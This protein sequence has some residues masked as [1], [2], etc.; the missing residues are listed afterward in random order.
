MLKL[1][2]KTKRKKDPKRSRLDSPPHLRTYGALE[3]EGPMIVRLLNPKPKKRK[4]T[5]RIR[6]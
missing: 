6:D 5:S 2:V 3:G 1:C 4:L